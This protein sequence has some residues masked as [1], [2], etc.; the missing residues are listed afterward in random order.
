MR[1]VALLPF[2]LVAAPATAQVQFQQLG[3][4]D[5]SSTAGSANPEYIGSNPSAVAWNGTD[6]YVAGFNGGGATGVGIVRVSSALTTPTIGASFNFIVGTPASRGFSGLDIE[7]GQVAAAYDDGAADAQGLQ[8]FDLA[9][10]A[11]W[12]FNMRGGSGVGF[13]PGFAGVDLGVGWTTFGSGRRALQ[14]SATGA[15]IYTTANGMIIN[16]AGNTFWRD[17]D[18]DATNGDFYGRKGN[19]VVKAVRTAGNSCSPSLLVNLTDA[20]SVGGQNLAVIDASFGK[21]VI[22]NDR[23]TTGVG[24]NFATV[25]RVATDAGAPV[26][27]SFGAFAPPTSA[28]YYDFSWN[29]ADQ[30]LAILDFTNR[31]VTIFRVSPTPS[32]T[33]ICFGD[34]SGTA[35]PCGNTG[36]AGNGCANSLN[37]NG[38]NLTT[39]GVSSSGADTL[40]LSGSGMPDSSA[41]YYQGSM[42]IAGGAGSVFGDG[43]RCAGGTIIRLGT[44]L[45]IA[46]ASQYPEAGD[47]SVSVRG[48][49]LQGTRVY[50]VWYRN[51]AAFCASETFNLTNGV[52]VVWGL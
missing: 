33:P 24:Q 45:N 16:P 7:G 25:V 30:T 5:L 49:V 13:D 19:D 50:Q 44:K 3:S 41:L 12:S 6:L 17:V 22:Y 18:F 37:A 32:S 2:A 52:S 40:V 14:N 47:L 4:V 39:S 15:S 26:T 31:T 11:Q 9:G 46:G 21:Y 51:A 38:A 1:I 8:V 34:G 29:A 35:C 20:D 27:A 28:G 43:L 23:A 42:T 10:L 48:M 36:A